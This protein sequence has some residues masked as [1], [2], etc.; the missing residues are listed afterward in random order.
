V[1]WRSEQFGP[2][3]YG[4]AGGGAMQNQTSPIVMCPGCKTQMDVKLVEP[5]ATDQRMD[6]IT[7][8]CPIC[9]TETKRVIQRG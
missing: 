5:L 8:H 4:N 3:L 9:G 2:L 6:E 1:L 7:Y